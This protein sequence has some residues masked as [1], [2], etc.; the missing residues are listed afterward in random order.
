[1]KSNDLEESGAVQP[2][3]QW[4]TNCVKSVMNQV[5]NE[6]KC[7]LGPSFIGHSLQCNMTYCDSESCCSSHY[8]ANVDYSEDYNYDWIYYNYPEYDDYGMEYCHNSHQVV[9]HVT[10]VTVAWRI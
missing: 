7:F 5:P 8:D 4:G 10:P 6:V 3:I 2:P 1:M 9:S